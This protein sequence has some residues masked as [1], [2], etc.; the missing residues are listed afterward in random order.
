MG[1]GPADGAPDGLALAAGEIV[2]D[3]EIAGPACRNEKPFDPGPEAAAVDR[4]IED[5]VRAQ[6]AGAQ[7]GKERQAAPA[8]VGC[9]PL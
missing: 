4:T 9:I 5:T 2:E 7:A 1:I 3:H 6:T 8:A